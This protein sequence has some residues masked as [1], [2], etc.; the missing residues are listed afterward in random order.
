MKNKYKSIFEA[1]AAEV[2]ELVIKHNIDINEIN[3]NG[4][5]ALFSCNPDKAQALIYH[6]ININ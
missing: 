1:T 5:N 3:S 6:G 2:E 4:Q